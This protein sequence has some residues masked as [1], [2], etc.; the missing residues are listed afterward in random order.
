MLRDDIPREHQRT[1]A[2]R[3]GR[4]PALLWLMLAM[5]VVAGFIVFAKWGLGPPL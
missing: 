1:R 3:H 4:A 5:I 2:E